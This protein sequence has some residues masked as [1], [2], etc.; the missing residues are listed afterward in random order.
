M[1]IN[2]WHPHEP[3][4][5]VAEY[6]ALIARVEQGAPSLVPLAILKQ[7]RA[8][9]VRANRAGGQGAMAPEGRF[10]G[11]VGDSG[12]EVD[13]NYTDGIPGRQIGS[14]CDHPGIEHGAWSYTGI[15]PRCGVCKFIGHGPL[16]GD[17]YD[18]A[19]GDHGCPGDGGEGA[20]GETL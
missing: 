11:A 2:D 6:D 3:P 9:V 17:C 10:E 14:E 5:T 15:C 4:P 7:I 16:C 19:P 8:D 18:P 1:D 12:G 20:R 13:K